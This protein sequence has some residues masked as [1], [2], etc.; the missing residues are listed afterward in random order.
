[1]DS[2][3]FSAMSGSLVVKKNVP[4][5]VMISTVPPINVVD[6]RPILVAIGTQKIREVVNK[7]NIRSLIKQHI[8]SVIA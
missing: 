1:M 4:S 6:D 3:E 8:I 7:S 5:D 2:L